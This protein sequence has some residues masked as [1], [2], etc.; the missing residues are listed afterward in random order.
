MSDKRYYGLDGWER[1]ENDLD[2]V[3]EKV[4]E[5]AD[6]EPGE[7]VIAKIEWPLRICVF[8]PMETPSE[9]MIVGWA[10]DDILERLDEEHKRL[11]EEHKDPEG[12]CTKPSDAMRAAALALAKVIKAEYV[13]WTCEPTGE[14][15]EYTR[16]Q[17]D[18]RGGGDA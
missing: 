10:L 5:D 14:V 15:I 6:C 2:A 9:E 18:G 12:D 13:S 4:V 17:W 1:L 3:V 8:K 16:E 11:D 7:D